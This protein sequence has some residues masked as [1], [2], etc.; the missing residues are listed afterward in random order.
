MKVQINRLNQR[1]LAW[2]WLTQMEGENEK[3]LRQCLRLS[4]VS[5]VGM[6]DGEVLCFYGLIP[7]SLISDTAYLW[8]Q[9][10]PALNEHVFTFV[11]N[12][13]IVIRDMLKYYPRIVGD[14][15]LVDDRAIVW[16]KWLGATF[17]SPTA[18]HIPFEIRSQDGR[19]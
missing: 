1:N 12:S 2:L 15:R 11:R 4:E 10:A 5:W 19:A 18:T 13:Q 14:C 7:P 17:G 9:T 6:V 16:L 8:L 3:L